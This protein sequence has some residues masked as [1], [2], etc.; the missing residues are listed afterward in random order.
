M[1]WQVGEY[2]SSSASPTMIRFLDIFGIVVQSA[3]LPTIVS[4]PSPR[5]RSARISALSRIAAYTVS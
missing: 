3:L 4:P 1:V 5:L 2:K